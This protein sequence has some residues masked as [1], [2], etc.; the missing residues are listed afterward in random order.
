MPGRIAGMV[1]GNPSERFNASPSAPFPAQITQNRMPR[2]AFDPGNGSPAVC[3]NTHRNHFI[4]RPWT[5]VESVIRRSGRGAEGFA[6]GLTTIPT[7]LAPF[8]LHERMPHDISPAELTIEAAIRVRA[9]PTVDW[10]A[11]HLSALVDSCTI[12][13][14]RKSYHFKQL[15][16]R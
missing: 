6:A 14:D 16:A 8:Q 1:N 7:L 2:Y 15:S 10:L 3:F 11:F 12:E 9:A 4:K 5:I 13:E